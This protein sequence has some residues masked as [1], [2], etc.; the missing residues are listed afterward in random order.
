MISKE[1]GNYLSNTRG[2]FHRVIA[3]FSKK[4]NVIMIKMDNDK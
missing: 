4:P 1:E 2:I 3:H